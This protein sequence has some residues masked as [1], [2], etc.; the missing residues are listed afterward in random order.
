MRFINII[1]VMKYSEFGNIK[2]LAKENFL[3]TTG[4]SG[5]LQEVNDNAGWKNK[6]SKL[7]KTKMI[8]IKH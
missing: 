5:A 4:L 8:N 1:V 2:R 3:A 7:V 6:S